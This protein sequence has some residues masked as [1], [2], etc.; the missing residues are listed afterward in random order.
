MPQASRSATA[1]VSMMISICLRRIDMFEKKRIGSI[2]LS[3]HNVRRD[4]QART[5]FQMRLPRSGQV[6]LQ[7]DLPVL[8]NQVDHST[9]LQE[10]VAFSDEQNGRAF[11]FIQNC[12][13]TGSLRRSD[14]Q[15]LE[16]AG[17]IAFT[18]YPLQ[19]HGMTVDDKTALNHILKF[20]G[21]V[22]VAKNRH[23]DWAVRRGKS[24]G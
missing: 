20:T 7:A 24:I 5:D 22:I 15:N 2:L 8:R 6:D 14:K 16:T 12:R 11:K 21:Y 10:I 9:L 1:L 17:E 4:Q 13:N 3:F 19:H 18:L 23:C